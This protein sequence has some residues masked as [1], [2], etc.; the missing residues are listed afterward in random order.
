MVAPASAHLTISRG[1]CWAHGGGKRC[2][3][4]GCSRPASKKTR[5][6]YVKHG[7]DL[8]HEGYAYEL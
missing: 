4:D 3:F 1:L 5:D 6:L 7:A 8:S 2:I